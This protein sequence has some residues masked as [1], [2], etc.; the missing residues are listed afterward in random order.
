MLDERYA[1][2]PELGLELSD[3][4]RE[5][6]LGWRLAERRSA[7][8]AFEAG[9]EGTRR[10]AEG[11]SAPEHGITLGAGW[12]LAARV[13]RNSSCASKPHG[14]MRRTRMRNRS[15]ASG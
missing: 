3:T 10:E 8:L 7:G 9:V 14:T 13:P 11:A 2:T 5:F 6:Q 1:A 15:T 4:H 12:R